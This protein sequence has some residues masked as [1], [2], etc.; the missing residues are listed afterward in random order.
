M[1]INIYNIFLIPLFW[2]NIG[3]IAISSKSIYFIKYNQ[4]L[5]LKKVTLWLMHKFHITILYSSKLFLLYQIF[6]GFTIDSHMTY[7]F[8]SIF[9][10][11][12]WIKSYSPLNPIQGVLL[13]KRGRVW[14][15]LKGPPL[16]KNTWKPKFWKSKKLIWNIRCNKVKCWLWDSV[17]R[18]AHQKR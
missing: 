10:T 5:N 12:S 6:I 3:P 8:A 9:E 18:K 14:G 13:A 4:L 15:G 11:C 7:F 17:G 1:T 16:L 2:R